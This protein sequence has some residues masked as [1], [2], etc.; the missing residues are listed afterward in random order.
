MRYVLNNLRPGLPYR[1]IVFDTATVQIEGVQV[2]VYPNPIADN[3]TLKVKI[4]EAVSQTYTLNIIDMS[5]KQ[6]ITQ[7]FMSNVV[8]SI[9]A[10]E[11]ANAVYY[12]TISNQS[13]KIFY[14]QAIITQ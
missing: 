8:T 10:A 6:V 9:D 5:G 4:T 2:S 1:E 14:K 3:K 13:G 11:L 7:N 12:I